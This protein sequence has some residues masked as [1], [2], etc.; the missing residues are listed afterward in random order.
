MIQQ[1]GIGFQTVTP[2]EETAPPPFPGQLS[3][4]STATV[5]TPYQAGTVLPDRSPCAPVPISFQSSG[6]QVSVTEGPSGLMLWGRDATNAQP[7]HCF[8][9]FTY[10]PLL[11]GVRAG[12]HDVSAQAFHPI[13]Y[14]PIRFPVLSRNESTQPTT[15]Q[16]LP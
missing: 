6:V 2:A 15:E 11:S 16:N 10:E 4:G 14:S 1:C 9:P 13:E 7:E 3:F 8:P 5:A 12:G